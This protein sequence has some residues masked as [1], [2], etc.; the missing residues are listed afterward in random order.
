MVEVDRRALEEQRLRADHDLMVRARIAIQTK[1]FTLAFDFFKGAADLV[2]P[3]PVVVGFTPHHDMHR[4]MALARAESERGR[5]STQLRRPPRARRPCVNSA[6]RSWP[7]R[8]RLAREKQAL[9]QS[10]TRPPRSAIASCI[11]RRSTTASASMPQGNYEAALSS[12]RRRAHQERRRPSSSSSTPALQQ[13]ALASAKDGRRKATR[14]EADRRARAPPSRPRRGERNQEL[15]QAALELA[16]KALAQKQYD[17]AQTKYEEAGKLFRPMPCSPV[18]ARSS[19]AALP[20]KQK[21]QASS[22]KRRASSSSWPTA[23]RP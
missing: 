14:S 7:T 9:A 18:C 1:N 10:R 8:E 19:R 4:E 17:L 12:S 2:P 22:D 20:R 13:Q 21:T 5:S 15:Y 3:Q 16:N 23:R 6:R 11:N